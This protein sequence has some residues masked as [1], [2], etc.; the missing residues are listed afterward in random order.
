M[1][2]ISAVLLMLSAY[3]LVLALSGIAGE[4]WGRELAKAER[5][6]SHE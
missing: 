5:K 1:N 4:R 2:E 6:R 3:L